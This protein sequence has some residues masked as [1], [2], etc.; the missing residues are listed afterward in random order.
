MAS[1]ASALT[2]LDM[3]FSDELTYMPGMAPKS[4]N[5]A[6]FESGGM[7][8]GRS[9]LLLFQCYNVLAHT[10]PFNFFSFV[11]VLS[12]E[13]T[14]TLDQCKAMYKRG[15]CPPLMVVFDS[16]EGYAQLPQFACGLL[17]CFF[18]FAREMQSILLMQLYC[19]S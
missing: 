18:V 1:L 16:R 17:V 15:E 11:Q 8:V 3:E 5:L 14:E 4:A 6:K 7:Q 13:D 2:A 10:F 9:I 19:R 12:K